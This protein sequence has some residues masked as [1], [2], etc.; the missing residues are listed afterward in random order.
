[1]IE[2]IKIFA[3]E[4]S[5]LEGKIGLVT[6]GIGSLASIG[7]GLINGYL[8]AKGGSLIVEAR[9]ISVIAP[10]LTSAIGTIIAIDSIKPKDAISTKSTYLLAPLPG[11]LLSGELMLAGYGAGYLLGKTF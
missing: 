6:L 9:A 5:T 8:S 10:I 2:E 4:K 1:M 3:K 7:S 11:I